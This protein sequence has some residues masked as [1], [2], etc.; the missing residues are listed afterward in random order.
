MK[1][2]SAK[3]ETVPVVFWSLISTIL[4]YLFSFLKISIVWRVGLVFMIINVIISYHVGKIIKQNQLSRLWL[5]I[6]P[7]IF[8][9]AILFKFANYNLLFGLVYLIF[10]IFGYMS[11]QMYR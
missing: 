4:P 6:L 8:C 2:L 9:V 3:Y 10:E 5:L 7:S 11:K 1:K